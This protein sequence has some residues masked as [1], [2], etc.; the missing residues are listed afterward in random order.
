M[1]QFLASGY[2]SFACNNG[3]KMVPKNLSRAVS[4]ELLGENQ[5][6]V[7][8]FNFPRDELLFG[9]IGCALELLLP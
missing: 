4:Q 6:V 9:V 7:W 2:N 3:L 8:V 1:L 5:K